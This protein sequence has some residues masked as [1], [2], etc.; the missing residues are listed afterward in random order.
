M[1]VNDFEKKV[2]QRMD[3]FRLRPSASVWPEVEKRIREKKRRRIIFFWFT[4]ITG[5]VLIGYSGN[6]YFSKRKNINDT[7]LTQNSAVSRQPVKKQND[8]TTTQLSSTDTHSIPVG[9]NMTNDQ[10]AKTAPGSDNTLIDNKTSKTG[11]KKITGQNRFAIGNSS[12][13]ISKSSSVERK[14]NKEI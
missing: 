7:E 12:P 8:Q 14:E 4:G 11:S 2:Q 1:P 9:T 13:S 3:E 6:L 10:V 5:L